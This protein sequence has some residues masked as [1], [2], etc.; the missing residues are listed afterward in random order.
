MDGW[1]M[2]VREKVGHTPG[3]WNVGGTWPIGYGEKG[4]TTVIYHGCIPVCSTQYRLGGNGEYIRS[5]DECAAN[6][7]LIAAAPELLE[8]LEEVVALS[9]RNT[10]VWAKA[11]SAIRKARG[12]A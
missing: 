7:R 11:K 4:S 10:D 6:A 9:D 12:V 2:N 3:P 8:A 1:G 5:L